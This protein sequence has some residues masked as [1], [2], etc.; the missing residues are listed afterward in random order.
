MVCGQYVASLL[1]SFNGSRAL[2]AE[3]E[4]VVSAS[5]IRVQSM[6]DL[7]INTSHRC[8]PESR[9]FPV[10]AQGNLVLR[11]TYHRTIEMMTQ[12]THHLS[13]LVK[14]LHLHFRCATADHP[15]RKTLIKA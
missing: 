4:I 12:A 8:M 3:A 14:Q 13:H 15:T 6:H 7:A 11:A 1:Q 2:R 5:E 10:R 9:I